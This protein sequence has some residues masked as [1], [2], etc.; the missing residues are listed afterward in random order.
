MKTLYFIERA[1]TSTDFLIGVKKQVVLVLM[2][3]RFQGESI[4]WK[5]V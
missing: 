1:V 4:L 5:W 3:W 2:P